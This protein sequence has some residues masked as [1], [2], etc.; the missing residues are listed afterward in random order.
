M[1]RKVDAY[2][3][4]SA[5]WQDEIEKLRAIILDCGLTEELK[6][7]IPCYTLRGKNVV[8]IHGFKEHCALAFFKGALLADPRKI[9]IKPGENSQVGRWI[10]FSH[11]R[12]IVK[13]ESILKTYIGEAI[14][15]EEA[16]LKVRLKTIEEHKIPAELQ[17][18]FES[19]P[20]FETAFRALTPGRQRAYILYF[21]AAKQSNTR[22]SRIE[23]NM[24]LI[25]K[26]KG[27]NDDYLATRKKR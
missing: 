21:S 20:A 1:N 9:L 22:T 4:K 19:Q 8:G 26:G 18:K 16:G 12:E 3:R 27:L 17:H 14:E 7:N 25:L 15:V 5:K 2:I 10:K 23:K 11:V 6:W 24:P 13:L